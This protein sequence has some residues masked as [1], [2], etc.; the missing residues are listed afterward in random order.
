MSFVKFRKKT[1]ILSVAVLVFIAAAAVSIPMLAPS[2]STAEETVKQNAIRLSKMDLAQSISASGTFESSRSTTVT[3]GVNNLTVKKVLAVVGDTVK[4]GDTLVAFDESDLQDDRKEAKDNLKDAESEAGQSVTSARNKLSDA[5]ETFLEEK[6]KFAQKVSE[7]K[8]AK[9]KAKKLVAQIKKKMAAGAMSQEKW[10]E[11]LKKAQETLQQADSAYENVLESQS[12]SN[13]QNQSGID[14]AKEALEAAKRSGQ[15]NIKEAKRKLKEA[16]KNLKACSVTAPMD[17][18]V[19]SVSVEKGSVYTGGAIMVIENLNSFV[20]A[21]TV[22]EY[23][24]GNVK[25]GQKVVILTE[26]S[27]EEEIEGEIT[28]IAPTMGTDQTQQSGS[29]LTGDTSSGSGYEIKIQVNSKNDA[30]KSGMT[31]KC[32][33]ILKE[34]KNVFAVP[35]DA[36]HTGRDGSKVVYVQ[37]ENV[38]ASGEYEE[39]SVTTGMESDYYV[40]VSGENL[41]EGMRVLI[42]TDKTEPSSDS[43]DEEEKEDEFSFGGK[44]HGDMG[45]SPPERNGNPPQDMGGMNGNH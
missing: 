33:I 1:V 17:G 24:I 13:K 35:Y 29:S 5:N 36:V 41:K 20:V 38:T 37:D 42:P 16:E 21:S 15:K 39:I 12:A 4:K 19:T 14:S 10:S 34:A 31:A 8:S 9:K 45:G 30:I 40:E 3:A 23:D 6:T 43:E 7:A 44:M 18:T 25:K 28:F 27:D 26:A 22:D 2:D 32:S 11:E